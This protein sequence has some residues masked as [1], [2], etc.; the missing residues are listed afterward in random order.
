MEVLR[1]VCYK[2]NKLVSWL[3]EVGSRVCLFVCDEW[4]CL[5]ADG[6][7][8]VREQKVDIAREKRENC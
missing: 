4:E 6:N 8:P 2:E 5:Y 7:D 1:G 3:W